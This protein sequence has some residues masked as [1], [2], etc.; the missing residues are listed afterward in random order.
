MTNGKWSAAL[1]CGLLLTAIWGCGGPGKDAAAK[2]EPT[3]ETPWKDKSREQ[4]ISS[5]DELLNALEQMRLSQSGGIDPA[6]LLAVSSG[7]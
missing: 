7:G 2:Y 6:T 5:C 1:G 4:R 3:S